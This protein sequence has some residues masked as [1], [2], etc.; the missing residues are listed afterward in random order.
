MG[1][2]QGLGSW[3][4]G[5]PAA[6][7]GVPSLVPRPHSGA[8]FAPPLNPAAGKAGGGGLSIVVRA[9]SKDQEGELRLRRRGEVRSIHT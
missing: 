8:C 4:H 1:V 6:S 3:L 9:G 5:R 2:E 7:A